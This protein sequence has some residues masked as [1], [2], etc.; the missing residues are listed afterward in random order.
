VASE[1]VLLRSSECHWPIRDVPKVLVD[2]QVALTQRV[3]EARQIVTHSHISDWIQELAAEDMD[4]DW[5]EFWSVRREFGPLVVLHVHH[6]GSRRAD[7]KL[8]RHGELMQF[9]ASYFLLYL[10]DFRVTVVPLLVSR[11]TC[12][13]AFFCAGPVA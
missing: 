4:A 5:A 3:P 9:V 12:E 11:I 13:G 10:I 6:D 7:R 2:V 8:G 1:A